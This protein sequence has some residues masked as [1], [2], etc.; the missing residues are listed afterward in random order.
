[1]NIPSYCKKELFFEEDEV[2]DEVRNFLSLNNFF[3]G[4]AKVE[5]MFR[6][7]SFSG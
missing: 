2:R 7:G 4:D 1:M 6:R 3:H 5:R